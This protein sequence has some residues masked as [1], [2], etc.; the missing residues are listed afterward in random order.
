MVFAI[1]KGS[2]ILKN[3]TIKSQKVL[4]KSDLKLTSLREVSATAFV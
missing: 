1:L 2:P 3:I 4:L